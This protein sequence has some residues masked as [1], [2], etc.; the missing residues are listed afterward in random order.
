MSAAEAQVPSVFDPRVYEG[1]VDHSRS[2]P[3]RNAFRY[4]IWFV[5]VDIERLDEL[6]DAVPR[7]RHNAPGGIEVRDRDHGP[8]DGSPLRPWIDGVLARAGID[9]GAGGRVMLLTFARSRLWSFY[10]VS[11]WYCFSA[12]GAP[13]AVL[14]EVQNTFGEHHSY[15]LHARGEAMSWDVKPQVTKAFRVSPFIEMDARYTFTLS[16]PG[17]ALGISILD[18]VAGEPLLLAKVDLEGR[19]LTDEVLGDVSG[20]LGPMPLRAGALIGYQALRLLA[21]GIRWLKLPPA[22]QEDLSL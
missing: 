21:R 15:L 13:K 8:R 20:R 22:P 7:L 2:R 16:E 4:R 9:L 18:V 17:D 6:A 12:D 11:F 19:P 14:A 3:K 1:W 10:P 5:Y